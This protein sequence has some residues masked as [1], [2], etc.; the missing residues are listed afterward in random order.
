MGC[1]LARVQEL[2]RVE[3]LR[4]AQFQLGQGWLAQ[5]SLVWVFL[6]LGLAGE[7]TAS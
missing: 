7:D 5:K 2:A 6:A 1:S 3:V 4:L